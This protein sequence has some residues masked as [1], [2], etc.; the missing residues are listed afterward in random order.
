MKNRNLQSGDNWQTPPEFYNKLNKEFNF[1]FDPCPYSEGEPIFDGL[2]CEWG[3]RNFINPPYSLKLKTAFVEKAIEES[4]K[5]KLCVLL[6]PSATE[7]K[8]FHD[9]IVPNKK[10]IRFIR[11]RIKFHGYNT[12]GVW[13]TKGSGMLGSM[14]V[15]LKQE[16]G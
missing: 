14:L 15:I 3:E 1:D 5:G 9:L 2:K 16:V 6:L 7:T 13:T 4:R 8:L 11:N 10:E 12:K